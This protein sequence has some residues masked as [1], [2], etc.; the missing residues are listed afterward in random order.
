MENIGKTRS[1]SNHLPRYNKKTLVQYIKN[2]NRQQ[3]L[4]TLTK[5]GQSYSMKF[6]Q[7]LRAIP[8]ACKLSCTRKK[9]FRRANST[10]VPLLV[11]APLDYS[12]PVT[13]KSC[14]HRHTAALMAAPALEKQPGMVA[15]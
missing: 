2:T 4:I 6:F 12:K 15:E 1:H 5:L 10:T 9:H 3:N 14:R 11:R 7:Y 8:Y 13:T